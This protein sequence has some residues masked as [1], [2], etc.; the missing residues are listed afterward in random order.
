MESLKKIAISQKKPLLFIND[1]FYVMG[2]SNKPEGVFEKA[3]MVVQISPANRIKEWKIQSDKKF[4]EFLNKKIKRCL[5]IQY[6]HDS[7]H[8]SID[9]EDPD[10]NPDRYDDFSNMI[11]DCMTHFWEDTE[12]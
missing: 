2:W 9:H 10:L 5:E 11:R 8:S 4:L 3:P 1:N 7:D 12:P 6:D